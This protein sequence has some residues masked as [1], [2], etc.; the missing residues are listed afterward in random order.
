MW[1]KDLLDM[2][3]SIEFMPDAQEQLS[4]LTARQRAIL[5]DKIQE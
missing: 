5:L 3:Y 1:T 2:P 4:C